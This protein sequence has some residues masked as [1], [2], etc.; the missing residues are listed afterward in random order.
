MSDFFLFYP[1]WPQ[2]VGNNDRLGSCILCCPTQP[3]DQSFFHQILKEKFSLS[4]VQWLK[5]VHGNRVIAAPQAGIM[6]A[7]AC[8][9]RESGL[10]CAIRTADCLPIFLCNESLTQVALIHAGWR[11]LAQGIIGRTVASFPPD[12]QLF[13]ALGPAISECHYEVGREV[14]SAFDDKRAFTPAHKGKWRLS[15]Y[16]LAVNQ[17]EAHRVCCGSKPDWCTYEQAEWFH[18]YR[19]AGLSA[20]PYDRIANFIW[21]N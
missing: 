13:A 3:T 9:T 21:L 17:L 18:S 1:D 6:T 5:Q 2:P 8:Y 11:S 10:A 14:Y 4:R 20:A 16:T 7:D 19:R 12:D 15:L